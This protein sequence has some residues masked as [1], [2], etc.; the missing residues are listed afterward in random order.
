M[1]AILAASPNS[2][3]KYQLAVSFAGDGPRDEE[4]IIEAEELLREE[5]WTGIVS[6]HEIGSGS[7]QLLVITAYPAKCLADI[8]NR[9]RWIQMAP[10]AATQQAVTQACC[11][12]LVLVGDAEALPVKVEVGPRITALV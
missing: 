1:K 6:G 2:N 7:A 12:R 3:Q 11:G 4:R 8:T 5:L 10:A 9:L